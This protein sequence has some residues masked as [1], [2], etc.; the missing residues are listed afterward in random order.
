LRRKRRKRKVVELPEDTKR[1]IRLLQE[2]TES[3]RRSWERGST[4]KEFI[5]VHEVGSV[6]ILDN[7][8]EGPGPFELRVLDPSGAPVESLESTDIGGEV[9]SELFEAARRGSMRPA[10]VVETL[11]AELGR[12]PGEE[13]QEQMQ[14]TVNAVKAVANMPDKVE[15]IKPLL[16]RRVEDLREQNRTEFEWP[17]LIE[18]FPSGGGVHNALTNAM[19]EL[20]KSGDVECTVDPEPGTGHGPGFGGG[21]VIRLDA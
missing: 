3:G 17:E 7:G 11:L 16:L 4:D 10:R 21:K 15:I 5:F 8:V 6:V 13:V 1:L 9:L 14:S 20:R 18:P 2:Q 19:H 12:T